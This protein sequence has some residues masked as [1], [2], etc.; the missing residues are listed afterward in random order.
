[1]ISKIS[2]QE[3][4]SF[5]KYPSG[6]AYQMHSKAYQCPLGWAR[7]TGAYHGRLYIYLSNDSLVTLVDL[8]MIYWEKKP[9]A[10]PK[11]ICFTNTSELLL[12]I[13]TDKIGKIFHDV[14]SN[15]G[16]PMVKEY[17]LE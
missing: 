14:W 12:G 7:Y 13:S 3:L 9:Q 17:W 16:S 4:M 2:L 1:M 8:F 15:L 11:R 10:T 6:I 5:R